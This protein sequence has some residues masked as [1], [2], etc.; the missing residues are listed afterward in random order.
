M[1]ECSAGALTLL[2]ACVT[3]VCIT[4]YTS[5]YLV[6]TKDNLK[7]RLLDVTATLYT[8]GQQ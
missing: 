2:Y 7:L 4:A 1:L 8:S 3:T 5:L 6:H